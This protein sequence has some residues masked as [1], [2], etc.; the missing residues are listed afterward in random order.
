MTAFATH[1]GRRRAFRAAVALGAVPLGLAV[2]VGCQKP[3]PIAH[4]TLGSRTASTE[5]PD[6]CWGHGGDTLTPERGRECRAEAKG[7]PSFTVE[8]GDTFRV[9]VDREVADS[10]WLLLVNGV[11]HEVI[12]Y[13]STYQTFDVDDLAGTPMRA[14]TSVSP[15]ASPEPL[16][17]SVAQV[18]DDFDAERLFASTTQAE[19][20]ERLFG[21]F[22]GVWN[23]ELT[24]GSAGD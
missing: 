10:G 23:A 24:P 16:L 22:R 12:P 3:S 20:D 2:L 4:F 21:T 13:T 18:S 17:I 15:V 14:E 9:G 5:A 19:L 7:A 8:P 6:D 1:L 11:L